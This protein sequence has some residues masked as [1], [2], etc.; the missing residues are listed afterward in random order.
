MANLPLPPYVPV[1]QFLRQAT[2]LQ[3]AVFAAVAAAGAIA[4]LLGWFLA[5]DPVAHGVKLNE[6]SQIQGELT[7][8]GQVEAQYRSYDLTFNVFRQQISFAAGPIEPVKWAIWAFWVFQLIGWSALLFAASQIK[9]RWSF[10]FLG[11]H[12]LFI[13]FSGVAPA[14]A[15]PESGFVVRV[16]EFALILLFI[17]MAYAFQANML[18]WP[19]ALRLGVITGLHALVFGVAAYLGGLGGVWEMANGLYAYGFVLLVLVLLFTGKEMPF[20][21]VAAANLRKD[22]ANS[23]DFRLILAGMLAWLFVLVYLS[24]YYLNWG[25]VTREPGIRPLHFAWI[26]ILLMPFIS[27]PVFTAARNLFTS[28]YNAGLIFA[29]IGLIGGSFWFWQ[30]SACD[31]VLAF[32]LDR[33]AI[34]FLTAGAL[35]GLIYVFS[36]FQPLLARRFPV[37]WALASGPRFS[38]VVVFLLGIAIWVFAEGREGWKTFSLAY[39]GSL[40]HQ[41]D[42]ARWKGDLER[43]QNRYDIALQLAQYDVKANYNYASLLL[44]TGQNPAQALNAYLAATSAQPFALASLNAANLLAFQGN[45]AAAI[46]LLDS[47]LKREMPYAATLA[48]NLALVHWAQNQDEKAIQ[49]LKNALLL[50]PACTVCYSNLSLLYLEN[51]FT[52]EARQFANLALESSRPSNA[53]RSN[54][55]FVEFSTHE[56]LPSLDPTIA[57]DT[58]D[59]LL[60]YHYALSKLASGD[61][62]RSFELASLLAQRFGSPDARLLRSWLRFGLDSLELAVTDAEFVGSQFDEY[63]YQAPYLLGV[64]FARRGVPEMAAAWFRKAGAL[65][66]EGK[67]YAAW[68]ELDEGRLDSAQ[69]H[70]S[71]LRAQDEGLQKAVGKELGL[72]LLAYG[73]E[74]YA[75]METDLR[76]LTFADY[77]RAGRYADSVGRFGFAIENFRKAQALDSG[78]VTPYLELGRLLNRYRD[79]LAL[80]TLK[81]GLSQA[82][83]THPLLM[84]EL[85]RAYALQ[86]KKD[87]ANAWLAKAEAKTPPQQALALTRAD[88]MLWAGDSSEAAA[89]YLAIYRKDL[90]RN[91]ALLPLLGIWRAKGEV[92]LGLNLTSEALNY[93]DQNPEIWAFYAWFARLGGMAKDAGFGAIKAIE[94][95]KTAAFKAEINRDFAP[96]IREATMGK[97]N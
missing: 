26:S 70:L 50:D 64:A 80:S 60:S 77:L 71:L 20:T 52:T 57:P 19:V 44:E 2:P 3:R 87:L 16:L 34:I 78:S 58:S 48:N 5:A 93:N 63:R 68:N 79:T 6:A 59:Y 56:A 28:A 83:S 54:A 30:I 32:T 53:A 75:Q 92:Q 88:L 90:L 4:L 55:F 24:Q 21:F 43:T 29:A 10:L 13:H 41:A 40:N 22:P 86:G 25:W 94:L 82:D 84:L 46:A 51:N 97:I 73:E 18:R 11:L 81:F 96:E 47:A 12:A 72:L 95:A 38:I 67:L 74:I 17:G 85:A 89:A 45:S 23:L 62:A 9:S 91:E 8:I 15:G 7:T 36:N 1:Y 61:S 69:I 35:G 76:G 65:R 39:A 49:S 31:P 37:F 33:L 66:P 14:L 42:I 27:Q